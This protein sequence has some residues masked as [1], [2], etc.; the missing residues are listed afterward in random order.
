MYQSTDTEQLNNPQLRGTMSV[1]MK[2][3]S[4]DDDLRF[5]PNTLIFGF[6][7]KLGGSIV[8]E[9]QIK[10]SDTHTSKLV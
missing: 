8:G 6:A 10:G 3:G 1:V 2:S 9:I 5:F 7:S 4:R